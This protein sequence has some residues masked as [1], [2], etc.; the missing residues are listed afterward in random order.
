MSGLI[1]RPGDTLVL[2][3]LPNTGNTS[4]TREQ[5]KLAAEA[6]FPGV[7]VMVIEGFA[8]GPFVYRPAAPEGE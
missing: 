4:A 6:A 1:V 7:N 3:L 8:G 2:P 5:I